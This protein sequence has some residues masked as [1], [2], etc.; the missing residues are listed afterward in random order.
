MDAMCFGGIWCYRAKHKSNE[1]GCFGIR[2][3]GDTTGQPM[4]EA[5]LVGSNKDMSH[6]GYSVRPQ[7]LKRYPFPIC[8]SS[9]VQLETQ[10][11][12]MF[13]KSPQIPTQTKVACKAS[14]ISLHAPVWHNHPFKPS[15]LNRACSA[16]RAKDT[17]TLTV[18]ILPNLLFFFHY[19]QIRHT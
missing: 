8:C 1:D 14:S 11:N 9:V 3:R 16:W 19:L 4:W 13:K 15:Q 6:C 12:F 2:S 10:Q 7:L 17:A 18:C 5:L